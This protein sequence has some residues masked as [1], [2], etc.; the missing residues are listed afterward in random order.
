[1]ASSP[2]SDPAVVAVEDRLHAALAVLRVVVTVNMLAM[3]A[4]RWDNHVRPGATLLVLAGL[5][6]WTVFALYAYRMPWRRT[7]WLLAADLAVAVAAL[8]VTPWL[9]GEGFRATVP[10]YW[11]M[12][13]LLAW[14][15]SWRWRGGL[16]AG[17]VLALTDV[18]IREQLTQT[19]YG[20]VFLLLLGGCVVG[21]LCQSLQQMAAERARAE[22]EAAA[23]QERAR[24]SRA[25][26]DG[27]LQVLSLVQRA[28]R[29]ASVTRDP[30]QVLGTLGTLAA[31]QE[32]RLRSLI[33][34]Q[35]SVQSAPAT[36]PA[37]EAPASGAP[38]DL[39]AALETLATPTVTVVTPGTE[40]PMPAARAAELVAAVAA[41]LDNVRMHVGLTAP[42]WVFL[43]QVGEQVTVSVRDEGPGIGAER[44]A[45]AEREGRLGV[46]SSIR[47]RIEEL[48]GSCVLSTG[49]G[50]TEWE[51]SVPVRDRSASAVGQVHR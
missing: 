18:L 51:L 5:T 48:G 47:G 28:G 25:V 9:K 30:A 22:R 41:C 16:L 46:A 37:G 8:A 43:E 15:I 4:W 34:A 23:A 29:D 32:T 17:A 13:A 33:R 21:Y 10:G 42:A 19:N 44:L 6:A 2:R 7:A 39:S 31:E 35:D 49:S 36:V 26:H 14:S 12:G 40:V 11:V 1:M 38:V 20:H 50:G 3:A 45:E 24:L 27:V